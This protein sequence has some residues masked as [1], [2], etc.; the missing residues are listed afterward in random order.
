MSKKKV[1]NPQTSVAL[2]LREANETARKSAARKGARK[3]GKKTA[4]EARLELQ[5]IS[6][7][8]PKNLVEQLKQQASRQG[9]G[10]QPF[11]RQILMNQVKAGEK[12]INEFSESHPGFQGM[13]DSLEK[14][15]SS[16]EEA[17]LGMRKQLRQVETKLTKS[18][19]VRDVKRS[20]TKIARRV[21]KGFQAAG[22]SR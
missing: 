5:L 21:A 18:K 7:R 13:L 16:T 3:A 19:F 9:I 8:L 17:M 15:F 1:T 22:G 10:Y 4:E 6:I 11:I 20:S 12:L 2:I 14:R